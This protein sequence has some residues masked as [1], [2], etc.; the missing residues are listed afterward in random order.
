MSLHRANLVR[1]ITEEGV[2]HLMPKDCFV[3]AYT[4]D[5]GICYSDD[6]EA[7]LCSLNYL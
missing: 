2:E 7:E 5:I 1:R 3:V 4:I 6:F